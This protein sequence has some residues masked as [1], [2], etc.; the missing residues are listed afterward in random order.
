MT[1]STIARYDRRVMKDSNAAPLRRFGFNTKL[2]PEARA[3]L[4]VLGVTHQLIAKT[5]ACGSLGRDRKRAFCRR[6][7]KAGE[8]ERLSI[9]ALGARKRYKRSVSTA[10]SNDVQ[11][12]R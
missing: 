12:R 10:R 5:Q 3:A 7:M 6:E 8:G 4:L 9:P 11:R 1:A 2:D